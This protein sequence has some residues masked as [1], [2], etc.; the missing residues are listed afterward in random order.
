[1]L[2][3]HPPRPASEPWDERSAWLKMLEVVLSYVTAGA[4]AVR[5]DAVAFL[6]KVEGTSSINLPETHAIVRLGGS[7]ADGRG[8]SRCW[9]SLAGPQ[10]G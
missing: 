4:R 2:A 5:L 8:W 1:M 6:W 10:C 7:Q 3:D 9:T